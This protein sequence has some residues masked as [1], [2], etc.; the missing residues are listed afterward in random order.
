MSEQNILFF[1]DKRYELSKISQDV[2][3]LINDVIVTQAELEKMAGLSRSMQRGIDSAM[4][5]ISKLL[6]DPIQD[7]PAETTPEP[8]PS[9]IKVDISDAT[10]MDD[11]LEH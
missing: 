4:E 10:V 11:K 3:D 2:K 5:T 6:P 7:Q 8:K 1:K 9:D